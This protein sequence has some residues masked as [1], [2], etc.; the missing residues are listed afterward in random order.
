MIG[1]KT[2]PA[3]EPA[4]PGPTADGTASAP[5]SDAR[6]AAER[7]SRWTARFGQ[8]GVPVVLVLLIV[9]FSLT[10]TG[11]LSGSNVKTIFSD[12][13][14]PT[15][16]AVGLTVCLVMGEFDLSL[17]GVAGLATVLV[18]VLVAREGV[19]TLPAIFITLLGCGLMVGLLNGVLVGFLGL[20]ALIVTIAVNSALIG[21]EY[22]IS[23]TKQIFGGFPGGFVSFARGEVGPAPVIV[24]LAIAIAFIIWATLEHTTLGR[25]LRAVGGNEEAARI[26]GVNTGRT[27]V[28]GFVIC[29]LLVAVAG[30][31]FAG[32]QTA[33][34][35]L[36]GLD[37]LLPSYAACFIGA[38]AFKVGEFSVPGTLIGVL[39]ATVTSNGLL[40]LG[41]ANYATYLI[42]AG[43]LLF[44]LLFA[45]SV[46][47]R[48]SLV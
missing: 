37:I 14:F 17:N 3:G 21:L 23:D 28:W 24:L 40:L 32:K 43:I 44:A 25:Q 26:A 6:A 2:I 34:F 36:S 12:A 4:P 47:T 10:A 5:E 8:I 9:V 39:I 27:K 31:L 13:A 35:P 45:R 20:S 22:V 30:T 41:V 29:S 48:G 1:D 42:Q 19:G 11:F 16:A 38:A 33:A 18:A 7:R 46:A 15:I